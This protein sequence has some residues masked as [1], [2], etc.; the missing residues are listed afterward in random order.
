MN[1]SS[2]T[3]K[4]KRTT[5]IGVFAALA[6]VSVIFF[7]IT[8]IGNFLT[9]D[10]KDAIITV[11]ALYMGPMSAVCLS[12][13]VPLLEMLISSTGIY[14][15]VMNMASSMAISLT[16]SLIYTKK[17]NFK[18]AILGLLC[19]IVAMVALMVPLNLLVTPL[20]VY[21]A[22]ICPT[23]SAGMN[24]VLGLLPTLIIPFNIIKGITNASFA[25]MLYKPLTTA[26]KKA[27]LVHNK[28]YTEASV[29]AAAP[30]KTVFKSVL[31]S[32]VA[33]VLVVIAI[34]LILKIWNVRIS[35]FDI[36]K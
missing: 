33:A 36:F 15:F 18:G 31:V 3:L 7:R 16:A 12:F 29:N 4:I 1:R 22:G 19:G 25:L 26:L 21:I 6:Y 23:Y 17:R 11:A 34:I 24:L 28:Q 2:N 32:F 20:Y 14:G 10:F 13:L 35:F 8:S 5:A 27:R 9:F 30:K